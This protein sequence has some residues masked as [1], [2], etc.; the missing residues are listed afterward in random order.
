MNVPE[1]QQIKNKL[2]ELQDRA[3]IANWELPYENIL[4][5]LDAATFFMTPVDESVPLVPNT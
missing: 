1:I 3:T 5:R 4:T 2:E